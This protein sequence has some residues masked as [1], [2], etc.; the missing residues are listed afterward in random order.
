MFGGF[1]RCADFCRLCRLLTF[2]RAVR[3]P[4][5]SALP[6]DCFDWRQTR[7]TVGRLCGVKDN[8]LHIE[9]ADLLHYAFKLCVHTGIQQAVALRLLAAT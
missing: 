3:S 1:G 8:G 2:P 6:N 7:G 9:A 5:L 4:C